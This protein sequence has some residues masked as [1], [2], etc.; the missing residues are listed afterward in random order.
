MKSIIPRTIQAR[1]ILSHLLVSL[2][3]IILI[4]VYAGGTLYSA[5]RTQVEHRYE[6]LAFAAADLL[7]RPLLEYHEV[8]SP[9]ADL[10]VS[11]V[12]LFRNNPEIRYTVY[13]SAGNAI[14]A[15]SDDLSAS[16]P[17]AERPEV[18]QVLSGENFEGEYIGRNAQGEEV[19]N[20]AV[21]VTNGDEIIGAVALQV[22]AENALLAARQSLATLIA[23]ALVVALAMGAVGYYL[24]RNLAVP[25]SHLTDTAESLARGE[26]D[27]R[28]NS[29]VVPVELNRLAH[30]FNTMA[31]RLQ[32]Y[33]HE[34]RSFVA[35][36][37]HELRTPL[38]SIKLR[39]ESL[40]NGALDDPS[41]ADR[42]LAEIESEVDR[43]SCMVNEMLDL[44]R[45]EG[46]LTKEQRVPVRLAQLVE[47]VYATFLAR[48]QRAEIEFTRR[49]DASVPPVLGDE[50]QLRRMLYNLVDN[51]IKYTPHNGQVEIILERVDIEQFSRLVIRDSGF[52]ITKNQLPH[53]FERFYRVEATR[54]R[55]GP[56]QGTGLGLAIAK[57]IVENHGGTISVSSQV[58]EGTT[59]VIDFPMGETR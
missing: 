48:T 13:D 20:L 37:S 47:D 1:L 40:R 49:V 54:P 36:A 4:S 23:S 57:S 8:N 14:A 41:V 28:V 27:S 45:I 9:Q 46:G 43:L 35:N 31:E 30:S 58:G 3:S 56:P 52:G 53:I 59:F 34:L 11:I 16:L 2:I 7:E 17:V 15:S 18:K 39:V 6:D 5:T 22:P 29:P 51:A 25:I 38:T 42:F 33:V 21:A 12:K 32:A 10:T 24:A 26:L 19:L 55:Y 44:S 50:E